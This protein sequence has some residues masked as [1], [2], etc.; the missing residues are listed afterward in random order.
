MAEQQIN[1]KIISYIYKTKSFTKQMSM[2]YN[3]QLTFASCLINFSIN[4]N[5]YQQFAFKPYTKK[6]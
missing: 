6:D 3:Y 1:T 2:K 5:I 4:K